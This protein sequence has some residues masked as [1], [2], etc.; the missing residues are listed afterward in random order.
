MESG[1]QPRDGLRSAVGRSRFFRRFACPLDFAKASPPGRG[2]YCVGLPHAILFGWEKLLVEG[3]GN[4]AQ[5][6]PTD[7]VLLHHLDRCLFGA[8][9]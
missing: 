7:A 8:L 9:R 4:L 3:I 6:L 1:R 2:T 5:R